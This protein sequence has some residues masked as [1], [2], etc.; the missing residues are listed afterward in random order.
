MDGS[1]EA[2]FPAPL[3]L[4]LGGLPASKFSSLSDII[5]SILTRRRF[6]DFVMHRVRMLLHFNITP[7]IV[8]DGDYLPSKSHTEAERHDRRAESKKLGLELLSLGKTSQAHLELQKAVDVTPEMARQLIEELKKSGVNYVV[9]PYEADSQLVYLEKKGLIQGIISEDS[10]LLVFGAKCLLTKLDQYGE[11]VMVHR[12]DF[13]ACREVSLVGWTDAEFRRMAILSGCDYLPSISNM[14]LKTAYRLLRKYKNVERLLKQ[15]QWDGKWK[16]PR[17]YLESFKRAE[18]T[19]LYQWVWCSDSKRLVNLTEPPKEIDLATM[20]YIGSLV[21]PTIARQVAAGVLHP[22]TKKIITLDPAL[23]RNSRWPAAR[24]KASTPSTPVD[25]LKKNKAIDTFFRP[26]RVPLAELDPNVFTPSPSQ[27][28]L[29]QQEQESWSAMP[30]PTMPT[31]EGRHNSTVSAGRSSIARTFS[32]PNPSKRKRLCSDDLSTSIHSSARVE[33]GAS[34]FFSTSGLN[35]TPSARPSKSRSKSNLE[36][37]FQIFSDDS[38][39]EAMADLTD[40]ITSTTKMKKK[41]E[42]FRDDSG[43]ST[44]STLTDQKET[45]SA[46]QSA[47]LETANDKLDQ[48]PVFNASI[49]TELDQLR[50]KFSYQPSAATAPAI[51]VAPNA[52]IE[53]SN[54]VSASQSPSKDPNVEETEPTGSESEIPE[55]EIDKTSPA[56]S[57]LDGSTLVDIELMQS[58]IKLLGKEVHVED[59]SGGMKHG[60]GVATDELAMAG[61]EDL[62]VP[63]SE[64]ESDVEA[65]SPL[66]QHGLGAKGR[67]DLGRFAFAG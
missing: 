26:N 47:D 7:F 20:E 36:T 24:S 1:I 10:D 65:L 66:S 33:S 40:T 64:V 58:P 34:R 53:V 23:L 16:I 12:R 22:H 32:A 39:E 30:A 55:S 4:H 50:S 48:N 41:L 5:C 45:Q 9:A 56:K 19:F 49:N 46:A 52:T 21:E 25:D 15:L 8:F 28:R 17:D 3:T 62:L 29:L 18:L 37:D 14:G 61:S 13:A 51:A 59:V 42:V 60:E 67:L 54:E 44:S 6:V 38:I 35:S 31:N 11:C 43:Y 2:L 27:Q 63:D 57:D